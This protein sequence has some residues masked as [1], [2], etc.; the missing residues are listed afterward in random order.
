[1]KK[2]LVWSSAS[3]IALIIVF[4][5]VADSDI[6]DVMMKSKAHIR[7]SAPFYIFRF[8]APANGIAGQ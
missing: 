3:V 7:A 6:P 1:M 5:Y 4:V 8:K 2:F